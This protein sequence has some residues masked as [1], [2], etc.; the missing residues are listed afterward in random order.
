M[1]TRDFCLNIKNL[2]KQNNIT[3]DEF[4]Y[5]TNI[6][7]EVLAGWWNRA[8]SP[9]LQQI[10]QVADFFGVSVEVITKPN[11][12]S[13]CPP[14]PKPPHRPCI[15]L[16]KKANAF[17]KVSSVTLLVMTAII[18][19]LMFC[20]VWSNSSVFKMVF[21][22]SN[23]MFVIFT[24]VLLLTMLLDAIWSV[25]ALAISKQ[26]TLKNII[27]SRR[28]L[29]VSAGLQ[30]PFLMLFVG[31]S[32]GLAS[33]AN[34]IYYIIIALFVLSI[35]WK[36]IS[37]VLLGSK[38]ELRGF[39]DLVK[40]KNW[41]KLL[42]LILC[43]MAFVFI[44]LSKIDGVNLILVAT[45]NAING[46]FSILLTM[47]GLMYFIVYCSIHL[48]APKHDVQVMKSWMKI[49]F[50]TA[51]LLIV[52]PLIV[53]IICVFDHIPATIWVSIVLVA[54]SLVFSF[55][56][57]AMGDSTTVKENV[58]SYNY[59]HN[60]IWLSIFVAVNF[61]SAGIYFCLYFIDV[62]NYSSLLTAGIITSVITVISLVYAVIYNGKQIKTNK[63]VYNSFMFSIYFMQLVVGIITLIF[64]IVSVMNGENS[65]EFFCL[66]PIAISV[67]FQI[68]YHKS[69]KNLDSKKPCPVAPT[70][71]K[72]E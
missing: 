22:S 32:S 28:V 30:F 59:S 21:S 72:K 24:V 36:L 14:K 47:F 54:I 17:V 39:A 45:T 27:A 33:Y 50:V 23:T 43:S 70:Q 42:M 65:D 48:F 71:A 58:V 41:A 37:A 8:G 31:A 52:L 11:G 6:K 35:A 18:C 9:N 5:M 2:C 40:N 63:K 16:D 60:I 19:I 69:I 44:S 3:L 20:P 29:A 61:L 49:L 7:K 46:A 13:E 53:F 26:F 57:N 66:I 56:S 55:I 68:I 64:G 38:N 51:I 15:D 25:F 62:T 4:C 12:S 34:V 1:N 10:Q 67:I